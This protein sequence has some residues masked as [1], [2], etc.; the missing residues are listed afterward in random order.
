MIVVP[1]SY[2]ANVGL[3]I[4]LCKAGAALLIYDAERF[5]RILQERIGCDWFQTHITTIWVISRK[6]LSTN[7]RGNT[8]VRP[9]AIYLCLRHT[10]E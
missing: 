3:A 9:M 2:S 1:N 6:D 10:I 4:A 7:C 8:N 5:L